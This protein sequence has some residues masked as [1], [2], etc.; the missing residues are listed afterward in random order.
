MTSATRTPY[1]GHRFPPELIDLGAKIAV[2]AVAA[3][4]G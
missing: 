4:G 1:A 2:G 3:A